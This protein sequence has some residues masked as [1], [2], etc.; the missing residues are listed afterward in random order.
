MRQL[1]PSRRER[2]VLIV[3]GTLIAGMIGF[4]RGVPAW[5]KWQRDVR[6][7]A[8]E[9]SVEVA[10]AEASVARL[11]ATLDSLETR[12]LRLVQ[13][14]PRFVGVESPSAAAGA[15]AALVSG[16]A[17]AA[18]VRVSSIQVGNDTTAGTVVRRVWVSAELEG[19]IR[20][21]AS[22]LS[23]LE[24]GP[25]LLAIR[26]MSISQPDPASPADVA[27]S[28]GVRLRVEGLAIDREAAEGRP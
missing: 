16:A 3:G 23:T 11:E 5:S 12:K 6:V 13:L 2:R 14:A 7:A 21:V 27:E 22:L 25:T 1:A 28:L 26:E 20:G 24:R 18:N 19:D 8:A 10:R 15:L 4:S 9:M 17:Q